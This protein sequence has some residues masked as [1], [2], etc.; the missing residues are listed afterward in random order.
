MRTKGAWEKG[1][2]GE[3]EKGGRRGGEKGGGEGGM[4]E[5]LGPDVNAELGHGPP[6]KKQSQRE[7]T[8]SWYALHISVNSI[9]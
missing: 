8:G 7:W 9:H 4:E 3:G 1:G 6:G 2:G 5:R